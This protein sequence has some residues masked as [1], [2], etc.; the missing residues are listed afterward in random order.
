MD[1]P[2]LILQ[3]SIIQCWQNE[4]GRKYQSFLIFEVLKWNL[5][6]MQ[7]S[8]KYKYRLLRKVSELR[9]QLLKLGRLSQQK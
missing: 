1:C 2:E 9:R 8:K 7:V 3:K 6:L 5:K 4:M